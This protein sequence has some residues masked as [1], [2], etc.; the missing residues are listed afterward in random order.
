MVYDKPFKEYTEMLELLKQRNISFNNEQQAIED[1]SDF[2]YYFLINGYKSLFP[3]ENDVFKSPINF[4]TIRLIALIDNELN[5][6]LLKYIIFVEKSLRSK[7]SYII[8]KKYGVETI[9]SEDCDITNPNDYFCKDNYA[10]NNKRNNILKQI[11]KEIYQCRNKN[12]SINHYLKNHNHL[13]LWISINCLVFGDLIKYYSILKSEDKE[14]I[15]DIFVHSNNITIEQK[16]DFLNTSLNVLKKYRNS[17]AH[18][19][20]AFKSGDYIPFE[21]K[22]IMLMVNNL[23]SNQQYTDKLRYNHIFSVMFSLGVLLRNDVKESY[24]RDL[25]IFISKY[26]SYKLNGNSFLDTLSVPYNIVEILRNIK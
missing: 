20:K 11:K 24:I 21:K 12:E 2:S 17:V 23:I 18:G 10:N 9:I 15:C 26:S 22:A 4:E 13:P 25:E 3:H 19:H 14:Y 16:K 6:L 8:S 7:I 1:L 5:S